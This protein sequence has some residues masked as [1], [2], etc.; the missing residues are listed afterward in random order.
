MYTYIKKKKC[1]CKV[2]TI[3]SNGTFADARLN[4]K[5]Y[6]INSSIIILS[7]HRYLPIKYLP[8]LY[9]GS[10]ILYKFKYKKSVFV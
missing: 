6:Y 5:I 2:E 1:S 9:F 8:T 7:Q 4:E 10:I 3:L